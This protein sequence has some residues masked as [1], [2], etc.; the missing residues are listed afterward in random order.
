MRRLREG[1]V[2]ELGILR[3]LL[4]V[5][6]DYGFA[7]YSPA[8]SL[9][10]TQLEGR[11]GSLVLK[12]ETMS[13][14]IVEETNARASER[15]RHVLQTDGFGVSMLILIAQVR[16]RILFE[17]TRGAS[18][19]VK[20]VGNLYDTCQVVMSILL[21]FLTDDHDPENG[22]DKISSSIEKYAQNLPFVEELN[23]EFGFDVESTWMLCRPLVRSATHIVNPEDGMKDGKLSERLKR[24]S[25]T[26]ELRKSYEGM[27]PEQSWS[28]LSPELFETFYMN[29]LY[30][31]F[32]PETAYAAEINRVAKEVE[33][34]EQRQKGG[35]ANSLNAGPNPPKNEGEE[36]ERLKKVSKSLTSDLLK[37][38][39]HVAAVLSTMEGQKDCFFK[40]AEVSQK[41]AN[42]FLM[43]CVY[44]RSR[45]NPDDAMY[46]ARFG[47]QLHKLETPGFSTLHYI[48]GLTSVVSGSLFGV[49]EGEAANLAILLWETWKVVNKWRYEDGLFDAEV[50][51]KPGSYM[52]TAHADN[53]SEP[54]AV[55]HKDF[56]ALYN[57]WHASLG[58]ALIGCL[59]S[60]EYMHTRAG[61]LV[62]TRIVGVF[63]T[64][65]KLGNKLLL[66]L[67]PLQ[68]ESS[69]RPDIR[70]SANAYCMMLLKAR[71]DGKWVEEDAA[72]AKARADKERAAA[73]KRKKKLEE[74]FQELERDSE[75]ITEEIGPRD[76]PRDRFGRRDGRDHP[77]SRGPGPSLPD[78]G[79]KVQPP[80]AKEVGE[81]SNRDRHSPAREVDRRRDRDRGD[82]RGHGRNDIATSGRPGDRHSSDTLR[83][84]GGNGAEPRGLGGR[85]ARGGEA[86]TPAEGRGVR[87]SKRSRPPSPEPG[88]DSRASSKRPRLAQESDSN[89]DSRRETRGSSPP[90]RTRGAPESSRPSRS[91]RSRR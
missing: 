11:A 10:A 20:L 49:T 51:G 52:E 69:S 42:A 59:K 3:T 75:K 78:R 82:E 90:R 68:D 9:S 13:F 57:S 72:V 19:P 44:P 26:E 91:R 38:D 35:A 88:A 85:W 70:A 18:K 67:E 36:L 89:F 33:R 17:S 65:P 76:G 81:V 40:S 14:G 48:D 83:R 80:S 45:Q 6:G 8:A 5:P 60:T 53:E 34:I 4:K 23:K 77:G 41:S 1:N 25:L 61:L 79:K 16:S 27:L 30:D 39:K 56:A 84:D 63:P 87:S 58:A 24:F 74:Q 62:L 86:P 7:D 46:C 71:D 73:E 50:S 22:H 2:M 21:A 32:C 47:F 54:Q 43:Q 12:R 37:Q 66:V 64:R 55:S 31:L 15:I 29:S 28:I